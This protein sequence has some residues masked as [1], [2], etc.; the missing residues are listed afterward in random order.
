MSFLWWSFNG[1]PMVVNTKT[2]ADKCKSED[3]RG[4][5]RSQFFFLPVVFR[6]SM[7]C[8]SGLKPFFTVA[9]F[10]HVLI[11]RCSWTPRMY[12]LIG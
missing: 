7:R 4:G 11:L 5:R 2:I 8:A 6:V 12:G 10:D 3:L 1:L 9:Q